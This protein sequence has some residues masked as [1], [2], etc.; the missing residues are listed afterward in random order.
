MTDTSAG[1][2]T[3]LGLAEILAAVLEHL[4]SHHSVLRT[5]RLVNRAWC[6]YAAQLLWRS[7]ASYELAGLPVARRAYY[8]A[9][10]ERLDLDL[11][12]VFYDGEHEARIIDPAFPRLRRLDVEVTDGYG[13]ASGHE[14]LGFFQHRCNLSHLTHLELVSCGKPSLLSAGS[15]PVFRFI[16]RNMRLTS[17]TFDGGLVVPRDVLEP[18]AGAEPAGGAEPATIA[19][20]RPNVAPHSNGA[21]MFVGDLSPRILGVALPKR[22]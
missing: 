20:A 13:G 7:A 14:I 21:D 3:A 6:H 9:M 11:T 17:L 2:A 4:N 15:E 8:A 18:A 19:E 16:A 5:A 12:R 1:A 10:V 22:V